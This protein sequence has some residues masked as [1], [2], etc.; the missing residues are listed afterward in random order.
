LDQFNSIHE[1]LI[2]AWRAYKPQVQGKMYFAALEGVLEDYMTA[3]YLRDTAM[4]AGL[5]TE[6][7]HVGEIGWNAARRCFVCREVC[8][9]NLFKLYPW[10]WLIR[11]EFGKYLTAS[12]T[13]WLE[14][15]WKMLLSNKAILPIL[16]QLHPDCP[17]LLPAQFE[18]FGTTF[19]KKPILGREGACV[20]IVVDGEVLVETEGFEFYHAS[21]CIYQAYSPLPNLGGNYPVLGSWLVN[22]YACG[23]GLREDTGPVT[24]NTSRFVPHLFKT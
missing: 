13:R 8:M 6:Y 11:E 18:P 21:P 24:Q 10:E 16:Y 23:L 14:P 15:P 5:E 7:L 20:S 19:V 9:H 2:E 4:Q 3:N 22:G 12:P 17:Y 1:R